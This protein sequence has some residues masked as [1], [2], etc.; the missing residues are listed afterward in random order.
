MVSWLTILYFVAFTGLAYL[1]F[2][3]MFRT[4]RSFHRAE[5][6]PAQSPAPHPELL[7]KDGNQLNEPLLVV[8]FIESPDD[9][10]RRL[11]E[12]YNRSQDA[13]ER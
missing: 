1:A 2:R 5:D 12:I 10:R 8:N 13:P 9:V 11:E 3:S 6:K 4:M 7:D